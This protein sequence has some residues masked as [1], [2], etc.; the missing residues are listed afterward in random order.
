ML[1]LL[2]FAIVLC[3]VCCSVIETDVLVFGATGAGVVASIAAS[4]SGVSHVTLLSTNNHVGAML[5]GGLQHTD[6][7]NGTSVQG[8][9]R[10]VFIR[11][12]L[13]YPGRPTDSDY[14]PGGI[15]GWLYESHVMEKVVNEMLEE[16]HVK[17]FRNV[18]GLSQVSTS[19]VA[20]EADGL[21]TTPIIDQLTTDSGLVFSAKT[22]IDASYTGDVAA[23][24]N[25][26]M[27]FGREA[28]ATYKEDLAGRRKG[29]LITNGQHHISPYWDTSRV[30]YD[31]PDNILPHITPHVPVGVGEADAW[32]EPFDFRLCFTNSPGNK[33][34]FTKPSNYDP[35]EFEL[36]RRLYAV[37]PPNTLAAAGLSCIGPIPN[38]YSDCGA[39]ACLKCDMLGMVTPNP[40]LFPRPLVHHITFSDFVLFC[41]VLSCPVRP[42]LDHSWF[43]SVC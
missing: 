18:I 31:T 27:T 11:C 24:A 41:W 21:A 4:R 2:I 38:N 19:L 42:Y 14:P 29:E 36:W 40:F 39:K 5:T 16:A 37:E 12:E 10:E 34:N 30:P 3:V 35:K 25:C 9:A 23:A 1:K 28:Q 20:T 22:F 6:S 13:Q 15:P 8:I 32:I 43:I 33:Y 7:A 17:V 26:N